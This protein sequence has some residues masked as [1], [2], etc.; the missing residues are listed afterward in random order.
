[1]TIILEESENER[2]YDLLG[3]NSKIS[4]IMLAEKVIDDCWDML[5]TY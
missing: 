3:D 2:C 1:M 5:E 4:F